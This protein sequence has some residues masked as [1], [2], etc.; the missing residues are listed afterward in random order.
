M[1]PQAAITERHQDCEVQKSPSVNLSAHHIAV[2]SATQ[3]TGRKMAANSIDRSPLLS[4]SRLA[5]S[6]GDSQASSRRHPL[7]VYHGDHLRSIRFGHT[8]T[9]SVRLPRKISAAFRS[10]RAAENPVVVIAILNGQTVKQTLG[11]DLALHTNLQPS[12][13]NCGTLPCREEQICGLLCAGGASS[14][15]CCVNRWYVD[16]H[17]CSDIFAV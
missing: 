1:F 13:R 14:P 11:S 5:V 6:D 7:C 16:G 2:Y 12:P 17:S 10:C 15:F 3:K 8:G 4:S 9:K